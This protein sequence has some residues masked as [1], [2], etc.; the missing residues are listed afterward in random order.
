[1]K[2]RSYSIRGLIPKP[3]LAG[4]MS[5]RDK[6]FLEAAYALEGNSDKDSMS[7]FYQR[8]AEEY[9]KRMLDG[10][11]YLS[12]AKLARLLKTHEPPCDSQAIIDLGCGTGLTAKA[13][14]QAGY[15]SI[16]GADLSDAMLEQAIKSGVY[17]QLFSVDLT[18]KLPWL[19]ASYDIA[20]CSGTFT[21]GH[22]D[23]RPL[24]EIFRIL[25]P[26]GVFAFTV[27]QDLWQ[28]AGFERTLS[29]L[30]DQGAVTLEIKQSDAYFESGPQ[31][32]W[33]CVYRKMDL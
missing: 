23:A 1:M 24:T 12:P 16:D 3:D 22:V 18:Q 10:L 20:V 8:W 29:S 11:G 28:S 5:S 32:G 15:G 4:S 19:S 21:H 31:D 27:H 25:K 7:V 9:D 30:H 6:Q 13:L 26:S 2:R 33:F 17:R 14:Q